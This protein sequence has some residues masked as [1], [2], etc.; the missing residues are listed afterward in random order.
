MQPLPDIAGAA[1]AT[2]GFIQMT[3]GGVASGLVA[4][5]HDGHSALSMTAV[6]A[7]CSLL[8]LASYLLLARPAEC[9]MADGPISPL[10]G[11]DNAF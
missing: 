1:G 8:A 6:M 7:L 5:F 11:G 4:A 3:M 9:V 10:E 2:T